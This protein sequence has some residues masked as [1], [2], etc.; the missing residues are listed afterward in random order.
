[1]FDAI[2]GSAKTA[3]QK[4]N[5]P[6]CI[7]KR[8][9]NLK[10]EFT[11]SKHVAGLTLTDEKVHLQTKV[12]LANLICSAYPIEGYSRVL[13]SARRIADHLDISIKQIYYHLTLLQKIYLEEVPIIV[14]RPY[15]VPYDSSPQE[16]NQITCQRLDS[17]NTRRKLLTYEDHLRR[18]AMAGRHIIRNM[19][20]EARE[21]PIEIII[22]TY[23]YFKYDKNRE[24]DFFFNV[25]ISWGSEELSLV[26]RYFLYLIQ[27]NTYMNRLKGTGFYHKSSL[28]IYA[29]IF[30]VGIPYVRKI[31]KSLDTKE[32]INLA[33]DNFDIYIELLPKGHR[34]IAWFE[35]QLAKQ[36]LTTEL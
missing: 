29:K 25:H 4:L 23:D 21:R 20:F 18:T 5:I 28:W 19:G 30:D 12:L 15:G 9:T 1:M 14:C 36:Q 11:M 27:R 6:R 24:K 34:K 2:Q 10:D 32:F 16:T 35:E 8:M 26:E 13:T 17:T 7:H 3:V 31:L 33:I 22:P